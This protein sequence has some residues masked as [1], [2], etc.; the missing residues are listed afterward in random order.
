M[1][2]VQGYPVNDV[3]DYPLNKVFGSSYYWTSKFES[4]I[5]DKI[6]SDDNITIRQLLEDYLNTRR[7]GGYLIGY[8]SHLH[9]VYK[10]HYIITMTGNRTNDYLAARRKA[11]CG[12]IPDY[13]WHHCERI[14]ATMTGI[15]CKMCLVEENYH[16]VHHHKGGVD[17]YH[18]I[19]ETGYGGI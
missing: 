18:F 6:K 10:Q 1:L 16:S 5:R 8:S 9:K 2:K 12:S 17:E 7:T 3:D 11:H 13:R 19:F 14:W 4:Y 15:R